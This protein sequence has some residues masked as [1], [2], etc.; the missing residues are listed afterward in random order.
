MADN[1]ILEAINGIKSSVQ[2]ME[3]QMK[4]VPSKA[5][6]G[7]IVSEI[8]SVRESVIRNTDRID[9]LFDLRKNDEKCLAKR[10]ERLVENKLS[11]ADIGAP[12]TNNEA[13]FLLSRK[14]IRMWPV[15]K[16]PSGLEREVRNFCKTILKMPQEVIDGLLIER[17]YSVSQARR[18]KITDE[19]HVVLQTSHQRDAIQSYA[20]NLAECNG[21][22]GI[23]MDIPDHLRG[24]FRQ[25][26]THAI[27]L[28]G[29]Y[30]PIKRAIRFD[31]LDGSLYMDVKLQDSDW[32]RI[33]AAEI[34][35]IRP[36]TAGTNTTKSTADK[37]RVLLQ[38]TSP[39]YHVASD[40][41]EFYDSSQQNTN[42]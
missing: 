8:R 1:Q 21:K 25:F 11:S 33:T 3:A 29:K 41:E 36:S 20:A 35:R 24:L 19:V 5:D 34:R 18:S 27:N 12:S 39:T 37:K 10:V 4:T 16:S 17:V 32:H 22:A 40:D 13:N 38:E 6:L 28:K 23:R 9:S 26:E 31:D 7:S 30:G 2:A 15:S 42:K 14:S